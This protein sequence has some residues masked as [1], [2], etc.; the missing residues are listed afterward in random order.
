M[1]DTVGNREDRLSRD[2]AKFVV[3]K[4]TLRTGQCMHS[5]PR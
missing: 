4:F 1:D 2:V 5:C 3:D